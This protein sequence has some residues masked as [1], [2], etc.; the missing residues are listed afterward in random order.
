[1]VDEGEPKRDV[2]K[3]ATPLTNYADAAAYVLIAETG[4]RQD[5]GVRDRGS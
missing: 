3:S 4:C 5:N 2:E 1:M